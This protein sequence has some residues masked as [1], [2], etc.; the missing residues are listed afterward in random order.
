MSH[1]SR[2]RPGHFRSRTLSL[3]IFFNGICEEDQKREIRGS[4]ENGIKNLSGGI[5]TVD[6]SCLL[7]KAVPHEMLIESIAKA[8][9]CLP[10][11]TP[12]PRGGADG[13]I[14]VEGEVPEIILNMDG[15]LIE[16]IPEE[17]YGIS[18]LKGLF[19]RS[20]KISRIS[21]AIGRLA[22]L[23]SLTLA[24]NPIQ[25]LP[26]E[27]F[28]LQLGNFTITARGFMSSEEMEERNGRIAFDRVM[29]AD[30]CMRKRAEGAVPE[31]LN[32]QSKVCSICKKKVLIYHLYYK[33]LPFR[34]L[35]APFEFVVCSPPC[36]LSAMAYPE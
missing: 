24:N 22:Q 12:L 7:I 1:W 13:E 32:S 2:R 16:H 17:V 5:V 6:W 26:A 21:Q 31:P 8:G 29:L 10:S 4:L 36:H 34:D 9:R 15:N 19:L 20:N 33:V 18:N 3:S 27:M 25:C 35:P 11:Q 23:R 30:M 28:A 14:R